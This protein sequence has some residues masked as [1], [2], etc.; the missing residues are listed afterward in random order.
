MANGSNGIMN[1]NNFSNRT[2]SLR[3]MSSGPAVSE[4]ALK[5]VVVY[6]DAATRRWARHACDRVQKLVGD[7]N[8]RCIWW[9]MGDLETP[10][11][12]AGAVSTTMRS[13]VVVVALHASTPLPLPLCVWAEAWLLHRLPVAGSLLALIDFPASTNHYSDDAREFLRSIARQGH[14]DFLVLERRLKVRSAGQP[15]GVRPELS[16]LYQMAA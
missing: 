9:K 3:K 15:R 4:R 5:M 8:V 6:Q 11:V 14:L 1:M 12:L 13:D 16:E 10:G 7:E 2:T